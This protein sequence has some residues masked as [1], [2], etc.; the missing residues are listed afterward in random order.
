MRR[1]VFDQTWL[2]NRD[3]SWNLFHYPEETITYEIKSTVFNTVLHSIRKELMNKIR[4]SV[5]YQD[6]P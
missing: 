4:F 3:K 1:H 2:N 5:N 6:Q